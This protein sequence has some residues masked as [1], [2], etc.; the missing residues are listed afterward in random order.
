METPEGGEPVVL[1]AGAFAGR[2]VVM[3]APPGGWA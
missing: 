1:E 3:S 2:G